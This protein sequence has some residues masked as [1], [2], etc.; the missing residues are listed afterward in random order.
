MPPPPLEKVAWR[1]GE[2]ARRGPAA[3]RFGISSR[4]LAK[5]RGRPWSAWQRGQETL[6][7]Q[8]KIH[9][10][11][12]LRR[13]EHVAT[14][15]QHPPAAAAF[16]AQP[17]ATVVNAGCASVLGADGRLARYNNLQT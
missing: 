8:L 7:E 9:P 2:G 12:G 3:R 5:G 17:A 14:V 15:G 10:T 11:K 4:C 1:P 13:V 6:G 16:G